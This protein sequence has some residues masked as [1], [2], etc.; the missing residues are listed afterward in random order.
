MLFVMTGFLRQLCD[1]D[2]GSART[3]GS[4]ENYPVTIRV[5]LS[6]KP[7]GA[8]VSPIMVTVTF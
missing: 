7:P 4:P 5:D 1:R 3:L 8:R 2:E 6:D